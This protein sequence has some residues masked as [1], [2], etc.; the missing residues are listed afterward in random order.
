MANIF[1]EIEERVFD[2]ENIIFEEDKIRDYVLDS[3]LAKIN[4]LEENKKPF[5]FEEIIKDFF[6]YKKIDLIETK[7]TRD[8]G[9]DGVI[10]LGLEMAGD[11]NLGL[12]IKYKLIDSNDIDLFI[13]AL[14]NAELQLGVIVCKDSRSL[15]KYDLN[16]KLKAILLSRGIT[17]KERLLNDKIDINPILIIKFDDI[18]NMVASDMRNWIKAVYKQ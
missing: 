16:S 7:K 17:L 18:I 13:L 8:F 15:E 2:K 3:I 4:S 10:K 9:L 12:Q 5:Y 14:R 11:I 6:K 1:S